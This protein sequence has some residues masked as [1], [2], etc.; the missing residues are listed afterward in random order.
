MGTS[1]ST[2]RC[3]KVDIAHWIVQI[4]KIHFIKKKEKRKKLDLYFE[5]WNTFLSWDDI[6]KV[7]K[8]I[9]IIM[10]LYVKHANLPPNSS[11]SI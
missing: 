10:I 1:R 6:I 5:L 4:V 8:I 2:Y 3:T 9:L 7:L 11:C